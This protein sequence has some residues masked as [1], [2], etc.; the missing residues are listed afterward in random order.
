[1]TR[2]LEEAFRKASELTEDRQDLIGRMLLEVVTEAGPLP[3]LSDEQIGQIRRSL[4]ESEKGEFA[5]EGAV[6]TVYKKHGA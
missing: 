4:K 3:E 5:S 2:L 1:M 6:D